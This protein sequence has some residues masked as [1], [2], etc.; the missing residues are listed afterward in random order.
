[1][2]LSSFQQMAAAYPQVLIAQRN[3][4]QLQEDN[5]RAAVN[6]WRSAVE[7]QGLL[8]MGGLEAPSLGEL[9]GPA[10]PEGREESRQ[11]RP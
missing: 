4:F 8:L 2:L 10:S 5:L 1:M 7:I 3:W 6:V 11:E 9:G